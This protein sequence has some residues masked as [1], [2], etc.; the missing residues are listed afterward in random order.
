VKFRVLEDGVTFTSLGGACSTHVVE[1]YKTAKIHSDVY[2]KA[3]IRLKSRQAVLQDSEGSEICRTDDF[4]K[5]VAIM[6][7]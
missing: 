2:P 4:P 6:Q 3:T 1:L 5:M 7:I